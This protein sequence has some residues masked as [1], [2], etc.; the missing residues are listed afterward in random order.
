MVD[1]KLHQAYQL[2]KAREFTAARPLVMGVL[3][4]DADNLNAWWLATYVARNNTEKRAALQKIL[5]LVPDHAP[6]LEMLRRVEKRE[7]LIVVQDVVP[8]DRLRK[9]A[10]VSIQPASSRQKKRSL[11]W[12]LR[13]TGLALL[14]GMSLLIIDNF[15]GGVVSKPIEETLG[16]EPDAIGWVDPATGQELAEETDNAVPITQEFK[17]DQ[18]G[19]M[20]LNVLREGEAHLYHFN[21]LAGAEIMIAANFAVGAT[22][23]IRALE[24]WDMNGRVIAREQDFTDLTSQIDSSADAMFA[25]ILSVRAII[26]TAPYTGKYTVALIS[27]PNGPKGQY[28]LFI[29]RTDATISEDFN[30]YIPDGLR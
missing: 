13:L 9:K 27:R 17:I 26:M 29:Q 24:L 11:V 4:K 15:M 19:D 2:I 7:A 16:I 21:A 8:P 6:A 18:Y 1:P 20:N 12:A 10:N 25:S 5:K 3:Q 23:E 22:S 14:W 30:S 28:G